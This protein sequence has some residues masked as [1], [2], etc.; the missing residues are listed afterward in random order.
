[1]AKI[2]GRKRFFI[3]VVVDGVWLS[4]SDWQGCNVTCGGGIQLRNRTCD[5]PH[6]GGLD[7][8]NGTDTDYQRCG[9]NPCPGKTVHREIHFHSS[10]TTEMS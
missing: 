5:G 2:L 6:Y 1:M 10:Y 8:W 3:F 7:C 9:T 4:W